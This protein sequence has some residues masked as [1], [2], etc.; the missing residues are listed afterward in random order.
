MINNKITLIQYARNIL[1]VVNILV[2]NK[3]IKNGK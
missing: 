1:I 2:K 3:V